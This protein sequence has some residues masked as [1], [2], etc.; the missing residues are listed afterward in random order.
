MAIHVA[1]EGLSEDMAPMAP[2]VSG[3][4]DA[5]LAL[6]PTSVTVD[7]AGIGRVVLASLQTRGLPA[8]ALEK[9]P[10]PTLSEVSRVTELSREI[11]DLKRVHELR[12]QELEHLRAYQR[13]IRVL[14]ERLDR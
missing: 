11:E 3:L 14:I 10:R 6:K 9:Q 5:L 13:D 4:G 7:A 8:K 12:E 2:S 1:I